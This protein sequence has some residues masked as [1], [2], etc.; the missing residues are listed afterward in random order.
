MKIRLNISEDKFD[1]VKDKLVKAGFEIDDNG[2]FVLTDAE[3]RNTWIEAKDTAGQK[4]RIAVEK[5][6]YIESFGHDVEVHTTEGLFYAKDRLYQLDGMLDKDQFF[7]VS[8]SVIISR[9]HVT[10]IRPTLS[11]KFVLTMEDGT[12]VDVTRSYY[13]SFKKFFGI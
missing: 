6:I 12:Q 13:Y 8:N 9:K 7:R 4:M 11:M 1:E 2:E 5:I 3:G 10:R